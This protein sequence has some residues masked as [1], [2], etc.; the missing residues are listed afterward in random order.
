MGSFFHWDFLS[1]T[2]KFPLFFILLYDLI[3]FH[4]K[5]KKSNKFIQKKINFLDPTSPWKQGRSSNHIL[6]NGLGFLEPAWHNLFATPVPCPFCLDLLQSI[7]Q[8]TKGLNIPCQCPAWV[9]LWEY[10]WLYSLWVG[11]QNRD[12]WRRIWW[13]SDRF[14]CWWGYL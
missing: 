3:G 6:Y 5:L 2:L 4:W 10:R 9:N 14:N 1:K 11:Y 13:A 12:L 7:I 8:W